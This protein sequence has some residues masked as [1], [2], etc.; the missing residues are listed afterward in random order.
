MFV[1]S[2]QDSI[3]Y[4]FVP[5]SF[6]WAWQIFDRLNSGNCSSTHHLSKWELLIAETGELTTPIVLVPPTHMHRTE[7]DKCTLTPAKGRRWGRGRLDC[8][9]RQHVS[10]V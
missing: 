6:K 3:D 1:K 7:A 4:L 9:W 5:V 8:L 2:K 10:C